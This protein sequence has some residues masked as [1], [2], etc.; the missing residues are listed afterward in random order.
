M[1]LAAFLCSFSPFQ[2]CVSIPT[3]LIG[4]SDDFEPAP[5][6]HAVLMFGNAIYIHPLGLLPCV[7]SPQGLNLGGISIWRT[8]RLRLRNGCPLAWGAVGV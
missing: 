7:L 3:A 4:S 8:R 2:G 1:P 6:Y 5:G